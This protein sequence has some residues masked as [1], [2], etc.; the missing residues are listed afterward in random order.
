MVYLKPLRN[1]SLIIHFL[2]PKATSFSEKNI[3]FGSFYQFP[4][5]ISSVFLKYFY[6]L[7]SQISASSRPSSTAAPLAFCRGSSLVSPEACFGVFIAVFQDFFSNLK[8][9]VSNPLLP[10]SVLPACPPEAQRRPQN[11]VIWGPASASAQLSPS[12]AY[13]I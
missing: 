9:Q 6:C 11:V 1:Y 10:F 3:G 8:S 5:Y 2:L 4:C 13:L 12:A 7:V